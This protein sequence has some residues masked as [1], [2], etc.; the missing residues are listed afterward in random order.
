MKARKTTFLFL[1]EK[2]MKALIK[3]K[4]IHRKDVEQREIV[5]QKA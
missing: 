2:E 3:G 5:I 4:P 1:N